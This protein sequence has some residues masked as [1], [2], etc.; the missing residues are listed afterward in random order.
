[1]HMPQDALSLAA[2]DRLQP[3]SPKRA[4]ARARVDAILDAADV[5]AA[6]RPTESLSLPLLAQA[7]GVPA[8][9][10]YHF[11]PSIEAVLVAL[12]RRYNAELDRDIEQL[13]ETLE[14][15]SWQ[16][17]TR[18]LS[19]C[20]RQF[21]DRN[22]VYARLVLRTAAF[23]SLRRADDEHIRQLAERFLELMNARFHMPN[24]PDL[25]TPLGVAM[26]ISDRIWALLSDENGNISDKAFEESQI[27][28]ISYLSNYLPPQMAL[29]EGA[30]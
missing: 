27:A 21:H 19:A 1:M 8:S 3:K 4:A 17:T 29:R 14:A 20:A 15:G 28:M 26:A 25:V 13:L 16:A 2:A 23:T 9:S 18:A 24:A 22:P 10:L 5:L 30:A 11:F 7:A 6:S 12:V